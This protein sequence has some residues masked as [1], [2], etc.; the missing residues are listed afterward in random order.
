MNET[1]INNETHKT[2]IMNETHIMK[3]IIIHYAE[4]ALKGN[5][6]RF[7][8]DVLQSN[9]AKALKEEGVKFLLKKIS[10]RFVVQLEQ[11]DECERAG[12][13]LKNVVGIAYFS[14]AIRTSREI[15]A[16]KDAALSLLLSLS[17]SSKQNLD[18][19][20]TFRI[21]TV[22]SDKKFLLTSQKVNEIVGEYI[23][24][25]SNK[26][27]N[28]K[29]FDV[30]I[31][32]EITHNDVFLYTY[33][34]RCIG[35]LPVGASGKVVSLISG[36]ID[37]PVASFY[38]MKRG[39]KVIFIHFHSFPYTGIESIEKVKK[40]VKIL[41]KFQFKSKIYFVPFADLQ[42]EIFTKTAG[43]LGRFRVVLYR[44]FMLRIAN[45]IS[46]IENGNAIITGDS[47]GQVASQTLENIKAINE[48][49]KLPVLR[50]LITFDK[51]EIINKAKEIGTYEISIL[52][53]C[54]TCTRFMP[55]HPATKAN[56]EIVKKIEE[57][58]DIEKLIANA[59]TNA[60]ILEI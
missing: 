20:D 51:E 55:R 14:Y 1:H 47:I 28:L 27:V 49:S 26:K 29:N 58:L 34:E 32:I 2:H 41:N 16:I 19:F 13:I 33:K 31:F 46:E 9:I 50:P 18:T 12:K 59:M 39:C 53:H 60:E 37:S 11:S 6:R 17:A 10:G 36:G 43:D 22:R 24:K 30:E 42:M 56:I 4:I 35:G 8:E 54:D 44:R 15:E 48:V 7:F 25:N 21:S 5:N 38:A 3:Y 40:I 45:K 52:P 23:I 57:N